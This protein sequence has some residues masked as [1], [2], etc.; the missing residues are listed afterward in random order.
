LGGLGYEVEK[1][2]QPHI[3]QTTNGHFKEETVQDR[4]PADPGN[5]PKTVKAMLESAGK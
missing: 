5:V 2:E 1:N 4:H 3:D